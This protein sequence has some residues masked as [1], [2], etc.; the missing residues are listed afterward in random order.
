VEPFSVRSIV[1]NPGSALN[2]AAGDVQDVFVIVLGTVS[3]VAPWYNGDLIHPHGSLTTQSVSAL[4]CCVALW[5]ISRPASAIA[6][7]LE[8][9]LGL[10]L[11]AAPLY[12]RGV[13]LQNAESIVIGLLVCGFAISR[14]LSERRPYSV[15]T[16]SSRVEKESL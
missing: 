16:S 11:V 2:D 4:V 5:A 8:T 7:Y 9:A 3:F 6:R 13:E 12:A 14:I 1:L 15:R 10:L